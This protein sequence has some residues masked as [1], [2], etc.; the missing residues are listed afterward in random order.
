ML[1]FPN[2]KINLG[3]NVVGQ[4]A[5][6]YHDIESFF[7]PVRGLSDILEITLPTDGAAEPLLWQTSGIDCGADMEKNLCVKAFRLLQEVRT[8]PRVGMLLHKNVPTGAGL[9]GGSSDG[10]F[11]ITQLNELLKLGLTADEMR[12]MVTRL[13]ADCPFF[14]DNKPAYVQGIGEILTPTELP[15]LKG[16]QIVIV[17][18]E[19]SVS[20]AEAY[21]HVRVGQPKK[22]IIDILHQNIRT[23]RHDLRNDFE[24]SVFPN[25]P[26][27]GQVKEALYNSGALYA[28][29]SGSGS[30]VFA[31]FDCDACIPSSENFSGMFFWSGVLD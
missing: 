23:W 24:E 30:A 28:Q 9:G 11:V 29:M 17:K 1:T 7:Y 27:I 31:I 6:G 25:H 26:I 4:R 19:E 5:N 10:T 21:S 20:T 16:K 3:L 15:Q 2:V 8:L 13:G 22:K 14:V 12:T 18:P